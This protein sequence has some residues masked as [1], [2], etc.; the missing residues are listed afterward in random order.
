[1]ALSLAALL[2][3]GLTL[4]APLDNL[5]NQIVRIVSQ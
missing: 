1:M 4:P 3:L 2:T 5:L